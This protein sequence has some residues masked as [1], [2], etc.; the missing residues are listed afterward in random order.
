[1]FGLGLA[2]LLGSAELL[3]K[4]AVGLA[5]T[6]GRSRLLIGLTVAAFGTSA[7]ELAIGVVGI[8]EG[9]ADIGLGNIVGSNI[10]NILIV[11][12]FGALISP[13]IVN[14]K[15]IRR[16][17]P[18]LLGIY[19]LFFLLALN[20]RIGVVEAVL[21]LMILAAYLVY[22]S[23][24]SSE[25]NVAVLPESQ[26]GDNRKQSPA[27]PAG[28][29]FLIIV[30]VALLA[31]G[32]HLMVTGAVEI[33]SRF[34]LSQLTVGLTIVA[35]GTSLPELATTLAAIRKGEHDLAIGNIMG[36]CLFNIIAVPAVMIL[37]TASPLAISSDVLFT[38]LPVM[39]LA[40]VA[41]LPVFF[42]GHRI[43]RAEGILFIIY[44]VLYA[45][46]LYLKSSPNAIPE[47]YKSLFFFLAALI[48]FITLATVSTRALKY[49]RIQNENK[50]DRDH[51][52]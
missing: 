25:R 13:I 15:T 44:Y 23:K 51:D 41:C 37:L 17:I 46:I 29:I 19:V 10:F 42:S 35:A 12:G 32:S 21:L 2:V 48:L 6:T 33:A 45:L 52:T 50:K 14:H 4:N 18:I 47:N 49:R 36:S 5:S 40:L 28:K 27:N 22:L 3:I 43:S 16:D 1:M 26:S 38:D 7:P 11:L 39:I 34:G 20:G 24:I 8:F 30:S 9:K 31:G